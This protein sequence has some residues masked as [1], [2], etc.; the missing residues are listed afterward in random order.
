LFH[1][2]LDEND[3]V[4][5]NLLSG[6]IHLLT[7]DAIAVVKR[8]CEAP[9]SL[10]ELAETVSTDRPAIESLLASLDRLGLIGPLLS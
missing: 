1:Q 9:A 8:L 2:W 4:V 3:Q 6:D 5:C 7:S 10:D